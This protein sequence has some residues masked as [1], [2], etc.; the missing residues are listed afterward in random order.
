MNET[1]TEPGMYLRNLRI[2]NF[3]SCYDVEVEFQ[4]GITLLVGENN[5]GKSNVIEALRLAT[6]PLNRR[7][8]RWFE[9]AD[10]A[11]GREKKEAEF[12][13]SYDGLTKTQRGH[14]MAALDVETNRAIYT[15]KYKSDPDRP[16][17][18]RSSFTAGPVGGSDAEPDKREQITHVYLAPLRDAKKE[19]DSSDGNRLL[20]IIRHLTTKEDQDGFVDSAN[21]SFKELKN[22]GVLN[23]TTGEIQG[24][25][26][27]L[28]NSVRGQSVE[29]TFA[30]Y[31]LNRL[32]R[33]LRVKMAERGFEPADLTESGLGY[34]NL[35]FIATVILELRKAQDAELTLFLV[36][37]PEAH[38][39]PQLQA[40]LLDYL[41]EQSRKSPKDDTQGP[42]GRIQVI[43]TTHSPNL[44]S[45]VG[46][47]N[48][49]A[50]RMRGEQET[51]QIGDEDTKEISRRKTQALALAHIP[52]TPHERRK[53]NQYLDATRAGLLFAR[54]VVLVE[55]V[56]EAVLL[57]VI[58][59]HCVFGDDD[60]SGQVK[61]RRAF[62]GVTIIN[63]G[64]VDFTPYITLLLST[65]NGCRLLERLTVITDADPDVPK[66]K[67]KSEE[68]IT[69]EVSQELP[70]SNNTDKPEGE[71]DTEQEDDE[72]TV[73]DNRKDRLMDHAESIGAQNHIVIAEAPHTLE[74]DLLGPAGNEAVLE[75]AY[76]SQHP[77]SG[78]HWREIMG[79]EKSPS[80][81]FYLKLRRN[82]KF[83]SK[84]EFAHDVALAIENGADFEAPEYLVAAIRGVLADEA[85]DA[86]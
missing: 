21:E 57:P 11:H 70:E 86:S 29:V 80:W 47:E 77:K 68:E 4:P 61:Q 19:L 46:I 53:V 25:L 83:I 8:T 81:G 41:H 48:I 75:A 16:H 28:T 10:L 30:D 78:K 65:V 20:R 15:A 59:R 34:A 35:L 66:E 7:A 64:S 72:E 23:A 12:H 2:Q 79:N 27:E 32:A 42:A 5:S 60:D 40:V 6:T 9:E 33:S 76:L 44:A 82:K 52:L 85:G 74:A 36:E 71:D 58:A 55:G 13:A 22:H 14:Y 73:V 56:A 69:E 37:E 26:G 31:E 17:K 50:L 43:A 84:G 1:N 38:L 63:V 62:H 39:H 54:R 49:V 45:S 24:H 3:R 51:I 67:K 18:V